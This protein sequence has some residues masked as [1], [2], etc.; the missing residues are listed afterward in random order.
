M[1]VTI[2]GLAQAGGVG[3][4]TVRYYQ[5]RGLLPTPRRSGGIR[6]YDDEAVRQLKFIRAA[7]GAGF[8]LEEIGELLALD[9]GHDHGRARGLAEQRIRALDAQIAE[10]EKARDALKRLARACARSKGACPI[11]KAFEQ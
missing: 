7:Q 10:L 9:A 4:E 5:R 1:D 6:R 2:G 8:T 3:V 11:I